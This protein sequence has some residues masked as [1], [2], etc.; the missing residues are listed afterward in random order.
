M[1]YK[2]RV[3]F[4]YWNCDSGFS[5]VETYAY[6]NTYVEAKEYVSYINKDYLNKLPYDSIWVKIVD[7]ENDYVVSEYWYDIKN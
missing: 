7:N 4:Y 5:H 1:D 2:Y 3:D 6:K